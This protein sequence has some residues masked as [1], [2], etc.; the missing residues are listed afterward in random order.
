MQVEGEELG[1]LRLLYV[2]ILTKL[3][4][5][6]WKTAAEST[7]LATR[8][9]RNRDFQ[10]GLKERNSGSSDKSQNITYFE[11]TLLLNL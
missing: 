2:R 9:A 10:E 4:F 8:G 7:A 5:S 3:L 6:D 11:Y 1:F